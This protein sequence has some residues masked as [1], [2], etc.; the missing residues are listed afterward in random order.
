MM[1]LATFLEA[2]HFRRVPLQ[3]TAAGHF[4]AAGTLNGHSVRVLIDT[5]AAKTV[6]SLSHARELALE[7]QPLARCGAGAG[8]S[9]LEVFQISG[10][11]L[12]LGDVVPRLEGL[13]AIDLSHVNE[14]LAQ[15]GSPPVDVV[16]G[17]DVFDAQAAVIDYGSASLFLREA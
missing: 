4:E 13:L 8:G 12:R 3:R 6:V 16:L 14:A 11:E 5:G 7:L 1:P 10:A 9:G 17:V 2:A 15:R